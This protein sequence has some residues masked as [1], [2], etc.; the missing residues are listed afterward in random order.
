MSLPKLKAWGKASVEDGF[1]EDGG[2]TVKSRAV[3]KFLEHHGCIPSRGRRTTIYRRDRARLQTARRS[4]TETS[5]LVD[6]ASAG[7]GGR[8]CNA[9]IGPSRFQVE[10]L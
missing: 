8:P 6:V 7:K 9:A 5:A 10:M 4:V 2:H 3:L 1:P